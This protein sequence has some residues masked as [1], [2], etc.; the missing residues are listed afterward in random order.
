MASFSETDSKNIFLDMVLMETNGESRQISTN[1]T[2]RMSL[3][4]Q[5]HS[6]DA[7]QLKL[8]RITV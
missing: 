5:V 8:E 4:L 3:G 7:H 1:K 6:M 2:I